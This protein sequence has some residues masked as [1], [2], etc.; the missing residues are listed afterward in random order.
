MLFWFCL[1]PLKFSFFW[2]R[3]CKLAPDVV[4]NDI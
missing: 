2:N 1:E 4:T 3:V